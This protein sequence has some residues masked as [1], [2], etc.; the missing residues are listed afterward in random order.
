MGGQNP[1]GAG[2]TMRWESDLGAGEY[3]V[4]C[5]SR[6]GIWRDAT[7]GLTVVSG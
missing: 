7:T 1:A 5:S 6:A 4:T 2:E 3:V